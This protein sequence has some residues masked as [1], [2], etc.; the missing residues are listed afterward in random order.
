MVVTGS[1]HGGVF[2]LS[3]GI[4]VVALSRS[5]YYDAKF[6]GLADMF[7]TG[8]SVLRTDDPCF[9]SALED[10]LNESWAQ[11]PAL[12]PILLKSAGAQKRSSREAYGTMAESIRRLHGV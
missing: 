10:A 3:Q 12:R 8:C 11:A 6:H 7:G 2:A 9:E 1:Y 4:P 5:D